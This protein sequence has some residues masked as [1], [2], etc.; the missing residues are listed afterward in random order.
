[1]PPDD[2]VRIRHMVDAAATALR[3]V[4]GK[5]RFALDQDEMLVLAL[6]KLVE[7]VGERRSR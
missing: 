3:F 4:E 1:M 6:T 5:D 7:I 2:N